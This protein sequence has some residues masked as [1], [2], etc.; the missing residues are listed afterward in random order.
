MSAR[1]RVAIGEHVYIIARVFAERKG[2][3]DTSNCGL[4]GPI[5]GSK[6]VGRVGYVVFFG[7]HPASIVALVAKTMNPTVMVKLASQCFTRQKCH[8]N[9]SY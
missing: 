6:G 4:Q 9:W 3:G 2:W 8:S 5:L 1:V 7:P